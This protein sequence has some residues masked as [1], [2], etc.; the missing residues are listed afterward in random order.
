MQQYNGRYY[1]D[2]IIGEYEYIV[3]G[4]VLISTL[5]ELNNT[6]SNQQSHSI[7]SN[8]LMKNQNRPICTDCAVNERRLGAGF[9]DPIRDYYGKMIVKKMTHNDQEAIKIKIRMTGS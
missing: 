2:L 5:N 8:T 4:V 3:N 7:D 9:E 1:E 6:Y